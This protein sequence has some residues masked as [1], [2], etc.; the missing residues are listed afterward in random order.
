MLTLGMPP[1]KALF[2]TARS[3]MP[4][5]LKSPTATARG[6]APAAWVGAVIK[7]NTVRS[8]N[9]ST[10][11]RYR[12]KSQ[13]RYTGRQ[14][15]RSRCSGRVADN[16]R[17]TRCSNMSR[18]FQ[19]CGLCASPIAQGVTASAPC[20]SAAHPEDVAEEGVGRTREV[21]ARDRDTR[22]RI[23]NGDDGLIELEIAIL[24]V[25]EGRPVGADVG[26]AVRP[27]EGRLRVQAPRAVAP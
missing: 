9:A 13:R 11:G 2:A 18:S 27:A 6:E 22:M 15:L 8:S 24:V 10:N 20:L 17:V 16:P 3:G 19:Q 21:D 14:R 4:S 1:Y 25:A 26:A 7:L 23:V 12:W 5:P